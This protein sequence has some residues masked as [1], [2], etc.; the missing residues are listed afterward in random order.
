LQRLRFDPKREVFMS[1]VGIGGVFFRANDPEA[2]QAWYGKHL[3]VVVDY[4]S[5]WAP[6]SGP[7]LFMPFPR[8]TDHIPADK[9]WMIN[10]RVTDL[11]ELLSALRDAGIA[12]ATNP[13]WDT[14]ETGRFARVHDPEGN[15]VELWEPPPD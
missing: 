5:P 11:D 13:E 14:P 1:V 8:D 10:F 7:T 15:A 4:A 9:Q 6:P 12:V 2:L 3:G